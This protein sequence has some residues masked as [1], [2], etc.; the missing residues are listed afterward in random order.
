MSPANNDE[1]IL[2]LQRS[3][4]Q[5]IVRAADL[6]SLTETVSGV[7]AFCTALEVIIAHKFKT[8]QFYVFKVRRPHSPAHVHHAEL[9][10]RPSCSSS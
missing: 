7:E 1:P 5:L 9:Y 4:Q 3:L 10:M 8:K 2:A 6:P